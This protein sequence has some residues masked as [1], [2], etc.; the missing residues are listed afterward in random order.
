[1]SA[2]RTPQT[3]TGPCRPP[4][5]GPRIFS[6]RLSDD[7]YSTLV[8]VLAGPGATASLRRLLVINGGKAAAENLSFRAA[9][10]VLLDLAE[11]G[12]AI[13]VARDTIWLTPPSFSIQPG[14]NPENAKAR[15][16]R[17]LQIGR[18]RQLR[19]APVRQFITRLERSRRRLGRRLSIASLIDSGRDLAAALS[20]AAGDAEK[21]RSIVDPEIVLCEA[22]SHCEYTGLRLTD[23]WRYFRHTWSLEYRSIPGRVMLLLIRNRARP[24]APV[25]GIAALASPCA[26]L[27][28]RD[29]WIGWT[30]EAFAKRIAAATDAAAQVELEA[31]R[32][33]VKRALSQ[34]RNDGLQ[35]FHPK[36]L[37]ALAMSADAERRRLLEEREAQ[38]QTGSS[39]RNAK[40]LP[41]TEAGGIDWVS[42][43]EDPLFVRKRAELTF[44][45]LAADRALSKLS[46][47]K[48]IRSRVLNALNSP[49]ERT[50]FSVAI[51]EIKKEG[52]ASK[53]M[54]VVVCGAVP[55]YN[56]LLG[57]K[58]VALLLASED[59]RALYKRK[60][61]SQPSIIASQMA[62]RE[63]YRAAAL[64]MLTTTSLYGL[65]SSQYN[66]LLV[67]PR[68]SADLSRD[69]GWIEV[70]KTLG[71][72]SFH[73]SEE[74]VEALR[75]YST[76]TKGAKTINNRFGEG[77]SPRLRQI[78]EGLDT[79]GVES[80]RVLHHAM[81]RILYACPLTPTAQAELLGM[82]SDSEVEGAPDAAV[83]ADAWRR[84]WLAARSLRADV[85]ERVAEWT[86][87]RLRTELLRAAHPITVPGRSD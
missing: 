26:H 1:M 47:G 46:D 55:P 66:R 64:L 81:L 23:V 77:A 2:K 22:N 78:R 30:T 6:P 20:D 62:G 5:N 51:R 3:S 34:L 58:L 13:E 74:T 65:G 54:D 82:G 39:V 19:E 17:L 67:R 56:E 43:S 52:I 28:I 4:Y 69:I 76:L 61:S 68:D 53:V 15:I 86:A 38:R 40:T 85:L 9:C 14:E 21:L 33:A 87:D 8:T 57:G 7:D 31:L 10:L 73:L 27:K 45:L 25:L 11:Q 84:R 35:E 83:L 75:D 24:N 49:M 59:I 48:G 18:D 71:F 16:R 44:H 36:E 60:Y 41:M 42:A 80:D 37:R 50:A 32:C 63:I 29:D 70:G 12:W 72:G 79:L